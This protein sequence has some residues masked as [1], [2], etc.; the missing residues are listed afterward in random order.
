VA[1]LYVPDVPS[2]GC[3]LA[4]PGVY[5]LEDV[6]AALA[7]DKE[8]LSYQTAHARAAVGVLVGALFGPDGVLASEQWTDLA[9]KGLPSPPAIQVLDCCDKR[10]VRLVA[11]SA[12]GNP[13]TDPFRGWHPR[14]VESMAVLQRLME[15]AMALGAKDAKDKLQ[16]ADVEACLVDLIVKFVAHPKFTVQQPDPAEVKVVATIIVTSICG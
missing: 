11:R 14:A 9:T 8:T 16:A 2:F 4:C 6:A 12:Y 1:V 15:G 10:T 3:K 5:F 13:K 7:A